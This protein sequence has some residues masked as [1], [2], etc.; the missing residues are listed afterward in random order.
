MNY[1]VHVLS[2]MWR[3]KNQQPNSNSCSDNAIR[4]LV[5]VAGRLYWRLQVMS[6]ISIR[7][8]VL[9][10]C[11]EKGIFWRAKSH[12]KGIEDLN[13]WTPIN[14]DSH[15]GIGQLHWTQ[16]TKPKWSMQHASIARDSHGST[17]L[18]DISSSWRLCNILT[19]KKLTS[20]KQ[21]SLSRIHEP[22]WQH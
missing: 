15:V 9:K 14:T 22:I 7:G 1:L 16:L 8:C 4:L 19:I 20:K 5:L 13:L 10:G 21:I 2:T 17:I 18:E 3:I 12:L 6:S 11:F